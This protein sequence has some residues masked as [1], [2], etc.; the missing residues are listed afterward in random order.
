MI[1]QLASLLLPID[2]LLSH[3]ERISSG[4]TH[5]LMHNAKHLA[6]AAR[7]GGALDSD[8]NSNSK[9]GIG[10]VTNLTVGFSLELNIHQRILSDIASNVGDAPEQIQHANSLIASNVQTRSV[11]DENAEGGKVVEHELEMSPRVSMVRFVC[12][13]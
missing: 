5:T 3:E 7:G 8:A 11:N 1:E 6:A 9:I 13:S 12:V 10:D 4:K 2:A